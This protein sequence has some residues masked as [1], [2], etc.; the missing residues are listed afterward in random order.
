MI[1][2]IIEV[3]IGT[4][5]GISLYSLF[6]YLFTHYRTIISN[7][8]WWNNRRKVFSKEVTKDSIIERNIDE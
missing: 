1:M 6:W 2:N 8:K 4:I 7:I 5:I 3:A